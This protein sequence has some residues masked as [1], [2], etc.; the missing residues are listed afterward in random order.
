MH[1][2]SFRCEGYHR[3][4][5]FNQDGEV[6]AALLR[7]G[8]MV[9]SHDWRK[10][11]VDVIHRYRALDI[12]K[13]FRVDGACA[14]SER[15]ELLKADSYRYAIRLPAN[16]VLYREIAHLM[17]P[18]AGLPPAKAIVLYHRFEYQSATWNKQRT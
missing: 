15:Y 11:L 13:S 8:N 10:V 3:I 12:A 9:S 16:V 4:F 7:H 6:Q 5:C 14:I 2:G 17:K 18:P 1:N